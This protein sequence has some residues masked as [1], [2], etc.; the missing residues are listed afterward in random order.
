M[1]HGNGR[2]VRAR[3][4]VAIIAT[5]VVGG[6]MF[7][8]GRQRSSARPTSRVAGEQRHTGWIISGHRPATAVGRDRSHANLTHS[9]LRSQ[10]HG[11]IVDRLAS[12]IV[13]LV[14]SGSSR[15]SARQ[16]SD[17]HAAAIA[18]RT[19]EDISLTITCQQLSAPVYLS[20]ITLDFSGDETQQWAD[21]TQAVIVSHALP[22]AL[23]IV[24]VRRH[25][26]MLTISVSLGD[27]RQARAQLLTPWGG[28]ES[29]VRL[30]QDTLNQPVADEIAS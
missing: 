13:P 3:T 1:R 20:D 11:V 25:G 19:K 23:Q 24:L 17:T 9:A 2:L 22:S 12:A 29:L 16:Y 21:G 10:S 4:I 14:P 28:R 27:N 18:F 15:V 8:E 6:M 30:V 26:S 7:E 5:A